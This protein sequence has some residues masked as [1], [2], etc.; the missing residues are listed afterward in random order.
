M[1]D[2]RSRRQLYGIG[3][4]TSE[5]LLAH[6]FLALRRPPHSPAHLGAT[7]TSKKVMDKF[8]IPLYLR[9][10]GWGATAVMLAV[11]NGVFATMR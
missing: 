9:L 3:N 4:I 6:R 1:D 8:T 2:S 10:V 7:I 5:Q 11:S